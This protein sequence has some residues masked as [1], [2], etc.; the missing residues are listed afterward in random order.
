MMKFHFTIEEKKKIRV[1]FNCN[2]ISRV[3]IDG[4]FAFGRDGGWMSPSYSSV[5]LNQY[6][7]IEVEAGIHTLV[8]GVAPNQVN[9]DIYFVVGAAN[10]SDK[11]WLPFAFINGQTQ[12]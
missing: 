12:E 5:P 9:E 11:Q 7:D 3:W 6:A 1:I 4:E 2:A 8:A 10:C